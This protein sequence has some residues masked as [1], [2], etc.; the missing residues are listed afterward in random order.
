[1][2][3]VAIEARGREED[4]SSARAH[5]HRGPFHGLEVVWEGKGKV[6]QT[7]QGK[8]LAGP[9]KTVSSALHSTGCP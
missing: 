7:V 2:E 6:M 4:S 5:V 3:R 9:R 8:S 1:M